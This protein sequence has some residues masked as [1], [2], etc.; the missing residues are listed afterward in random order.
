MAAKWTVSPSDGVT[1]P[2][3]GE[4]KFPKDIRKTYKIIYDDEGKFIHREF[5]YEF[6]PQNV[7]LNKSLRDDESVSYE[8]GKVTV[9]YGYTECDDVKAKDV[10]LIV[11]DLRTDASYTRNDIGEGKAEFIFPQNKAMEGKDLIM[12]VRF[13]DSNGPEVSIYQKSPYE[14]DIPESDYILFTYTWTADDGVDLDTLTNITVEN[15][16]GQQMTKNFTNSPVGYNTGKIVYTEKG[17]PALVW[18][19]DNT[20]SGPE[21]SIICLSNILSSGEVSN[22]ETIKVGVYANWYST[23]KNGWATMTCKGYKAKDGIIP[24]YEKDFTLANQ[25][26]KPNM[27]RLDTSWDDA[28][29]RYSKNITACGWKSDNVLTTRTHVCD[30]VFKIGEEDKMKRSL[31]VKDETTNGVV[32]C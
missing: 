19:T 28:T 13:C 20:G 6:C 8:G 16:Q 2:N 5:D 31:F 24:D 26:F 32:G 29:A 21:S 27:S 15:A 18:G 14:I 3:T 10:Q 23:R 7:F 4:F 25:E 9:D 17:K 1:N 22:F 11:D 12:Y 30:M